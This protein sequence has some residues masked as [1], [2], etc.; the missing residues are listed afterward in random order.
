VKWLRKYWRWVVPALLAFSLFIVLPASVAHLME[1]SR[2]ADLGTYIYGIATA[3]IAFTALVGGVLA[4]RQYREQ[5]EHNRQQRDRQAQI[6]MVRLQGQLVEMLREQCKRLE[7][8]AERK[9]VFGE[10]EEAERVFLGMVR[11]LLS[12]EMGATA[13]RALTPFLQEATA[14]LQEAT[15]E[16]ERLRRKGGGRP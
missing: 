7:D 5:Q 1:S 3:V 15:A 9:L 12:K 11:G 6:E 14:E 13:R 2:Q 8:E 10:M 4:V 16:L